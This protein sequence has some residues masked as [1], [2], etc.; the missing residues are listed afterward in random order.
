[1]GLDG[2]TPL[3]I[4]IVIERGCKSRVIARFESSADRLGGRKVTLV[5]QTRHDP[6]STPREGGRVGLF[7]KMAYMRRLRSK[8]A[9]D[10]TS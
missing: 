7:P 10:F 2:T 6:T 5:Y 3:E 9:R 1:M 4:E 8:G